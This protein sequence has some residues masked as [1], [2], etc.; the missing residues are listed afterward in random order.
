MRLPGSSLHEWREPSIHRQA[1]KETRR[2]VQTDAVL[3]VRRCPA[4][5]EC[6]RNRNLVDIAPLQ[7]GDVAQRHCDGERADD[8]S[9]I[10]EV[11]EIH[12]LCARRSV[13]SL[14]G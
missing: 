10:G 2:L 9:K 8:L 12:A 3:R 1:G 14:K 6:T 11:V 4:T 5:D 7:F 13:K